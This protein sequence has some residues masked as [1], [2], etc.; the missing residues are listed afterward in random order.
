METVLQKFSRLLWLL[1]IPLLVLPFIE[2]TYLT[3]VLPVLFCMLGVEILCAIY[4]WCLVRENW[5]C[6]IA[7]TW[8]FVCVLAAFMENSSLWKSF[9]KKYFFYFL[10]LMLL[11]YTGLRAGM[12]FSFFP[13]KLNAVFERA[14]KLCSLERICPRNY[15]GF[16]RLVCLASSLA[17]LS[18][19]LYYGCFPAFTDN[20]P[21]YRYLYFNGPYTSSLVR[22][23]FRAFSAISVVS[24]LFLVV[25]LKKREGGHN[26]LLSCPIA[27]LALFCS[28][29]SG[30]RGDISLIVLFIFIMIIFSMSGRKRVFAS[31]ALLLVFSVFFGFFSYYRVKYS[32][33]LLGFFPEAFDASILLAAFHKE[34]IPWAMGKTYLAAFLSFIPSSVFPFRE[35]YGFG[36]YSLDILFSGNAAP[37][38][39]GLRPSFVGEAYLNFGIP[40]I[41]FIGYILGA[42]LG[43]WQKGTESLRNCSGA[44]VFLFL[45]SLLTVMVSDFYG[46]FHA[47]FLI[48]LMAWATRWIMKRAGHEA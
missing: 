36:R 18:I 47:F 42:V 7:A 20:P 43:L 12:H 10:W 44:M 17:V 3:K 46:I 23:A 26:L 25:F 37:T 30:S 13:S 11:G 4:S 19:Y 48:V 41:F 34:E 32:L 9:S 6:F 22:F 38:Y 40:G 33:N 45:F 24:L 5:P 8:L 39:G 1:S 21:F 29:A 27:L 31:L 14:A 15:V 16:T 35:T 2:P 28:F